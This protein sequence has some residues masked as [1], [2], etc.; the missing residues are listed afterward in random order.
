M[1]RKRRVFLDLDQS[2]LTGPVCARLIVKF[3]LIEKGA[4]YGQEDVYPRNQHWP[5]HGPPVLAFVYP[6]KPFAEQGASANQPESGAHDRSASA[7][8]YTGGIIYL[9]GLM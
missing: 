5:P 9:N 7:A 8:E 3:N 6:K 4:G 2:N 1:S